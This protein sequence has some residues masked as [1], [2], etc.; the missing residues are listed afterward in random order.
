MVADGSL[1][2]NVGIIRRCA[3]GRGEDVCSPHHPLVS[4]MWG[5]ERPL[6]WFGWLLAYATTRV[7]HQ[8]PSPPHSAWL[9]ETPCIV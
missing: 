3:E 4:C 9:A 2:W 6:R 5:R 1:R 8:T 7:F